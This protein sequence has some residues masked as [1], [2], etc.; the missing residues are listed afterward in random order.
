M[1]DAPLSTR[2]LVS[3]HAEAL[4]HC[5]RGLAAEARLSE[6]AARLGVLPMLLYLS[7]CARSVEKCQAGRSRLDRAQDRLCA[8]LCARLAAS[9]EAPAAPQ[10][11]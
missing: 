3:G 11:A 4:A 10:T 5:R 9:K 7:A 6:A 1:E 2:Y 8:R